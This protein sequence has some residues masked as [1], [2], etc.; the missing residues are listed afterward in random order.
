MW[1]SV[2]VV[3]AAAAAAVAETKAEAEAETKA[4]AEAATEAE[5][6][7]E[8]EA[9]TAAAAA[10]AAAAAPQPFWPNLET[11]VLLSSLRAIGP[12]LVTIVAPCDRIRATVRHQSSVHFLGFRSDDVPS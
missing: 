6:E 11:M 2:V 12:S 10:A 8:T 5:T 3:V 1:G 9:A 4:E 7:A